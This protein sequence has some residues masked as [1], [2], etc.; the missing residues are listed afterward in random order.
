M[1]HH[2]IKQADFHAFILDIY[3]G[4]MICM[5]VCVYMYVCIMFIYVLCLYVY[6]CIYAYSRH[7]WRYDDMYVCWCMYAYMYICIHVYMYTC[8]YVYT[9]NMFG[10]SLYHFVCLSVYMC[11]ERVW[12][13]GT[14]SSPQ[15][16]YVTS[17]Y[18]LCHII[19]HTMS[20]HHTYYVTSS[21]AHRSPGTQTRARDLYGTIVGYFSRHSI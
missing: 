16:I 20:H 3:D 4:M 18:I 17:S 5:Y 21:A 12:H 9:Y 10:K 19:I 8:I 1:S 7:W 13:A 2:V 15:P 11:K 14:S 6:L